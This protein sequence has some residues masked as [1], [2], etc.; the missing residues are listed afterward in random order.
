VA[1]VFGTIAFAARTRARRALG[2]QRVIAMNEGTDF[3]DL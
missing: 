2:W 3:S 1:G